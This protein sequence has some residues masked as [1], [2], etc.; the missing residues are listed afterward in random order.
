MNS[1]PGDTV[2]LPSPVLEAR[3]LDGSHQAPCLSRRDQVADQKKVESCP[4]PRL[5]TSP[6]TSELVTIEIDKPFAKLIPINLEARQAFHDT[7][8]AAKKGVVLERHE[9]FIRVEGVRVACIMSP[10]LDGTD[11]E[12]DSELG[13][14][15]SNHL[16]LLDGHY[17]FYLPK[18][19][20]LLGPQGFRIGYGRAKDHGNKV[21]ILLLPPSSDR[22]ATSKLNSHSIAHSHALIRYNEKSGVLVLVPLS[23]HHAIRYLTADNEP[24]FAGDSRVLFRRTNIIMIGNLQY[25]FEYVLDEEEYI[26]YVERRN[27]FLQHHFPNSPTP[28]PYIRAF[29]K[30]DDDYLCVRNI[31]LH[32]SIDSGAFGVVSAGVDRERGLPLAIKEICLKNIHARTVFEAEISIAQEFTE[33]WLRRFWDSARDC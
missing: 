1:G 9:S 24:L 3:N 6:S 25:C 20:D 14:I 23:P 28:S 22:S 2:P 32:R 7:A 12:T 4:E 13:N 15:N 8:I 27:S 33:V 5:E 21:D 26:S 29:P 31:I 16:E 11:T 17:V 30:Q 18:S 19:Q 10:P